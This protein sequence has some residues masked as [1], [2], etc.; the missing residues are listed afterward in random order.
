MSGSPRGLSFFNLFLFF[1]SLCFWCGAFDVIL[2]LNQAWVPSPVGSKAHLL[3]L[4]CCEGKC[5]VYCRRQERSPG[6]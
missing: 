4:G 5:G 3:T 2:V 1:G 6:S